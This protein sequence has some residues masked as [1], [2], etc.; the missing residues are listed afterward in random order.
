MT[1]I[2]IRALN[3]ETSKVLARVKA[4]EEITVTER[5]AAIARI[6]PAPT[7]PLDELIS[8]GRVRPAMTHG[9][10]PRP[11]V[12]ASGSTEAGALVRSMRDE[13]RY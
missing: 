3:Q 12:P 7:G 11:T 8:A 2:S 1:E 9:P 4:G 10:A 6:V 5:G 13:E